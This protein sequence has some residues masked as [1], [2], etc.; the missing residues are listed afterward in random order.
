MKVEVDPTGGLGQEELLKRLS[1]L[2][3]EAAKRFLGLSA[4]E[5]RLR[6]QLSD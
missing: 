1:G 3:R 2:A 6:V 5:A 4:V